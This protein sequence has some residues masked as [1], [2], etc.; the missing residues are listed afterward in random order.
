MLLKCLEDQSYSTLKKCQVCQGCNTWISCT[1]PQYCH[2]IGSDESWFRMIYRRDTQWILMFLKL[3]I[4][5]IF[6]LKADN[7]HPLVCRYCTV[8]CEYC[9]VRIHE[10]WAVNIHH[11]NIRSWWR[12]TISKCFKLS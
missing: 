4:P 5:Q 10:F 12:I 1:E 9:I 2:L 3:L 7:S 6:S 11:W 8:K